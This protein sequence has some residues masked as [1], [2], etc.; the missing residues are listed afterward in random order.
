MKVKELKAQLEKIDPN[1]D[2]ICYAEEDEDSDGS[3]VTRI[4]EI[5]DVTASEA[6]RSRDKDG[7]PQLTF[8]ST[9]RSTKIAFINLLSDF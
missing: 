1:L 3:I 5:D 6:E 7:V 4:F 9:D 8:G 2:V